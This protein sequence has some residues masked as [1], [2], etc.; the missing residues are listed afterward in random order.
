MSQV[1]GPTGIG[2]SQYRGNIA[3]NVSTGIGSED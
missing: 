3:N 1:A 2:E